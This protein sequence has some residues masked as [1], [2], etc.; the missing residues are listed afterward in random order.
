VGAPSEVFLVDLAVEHLAHAVEAALV[1][2]TVST[3][4]RPARCSSSR[5]VDIAVEHQA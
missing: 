5:R 4:A 2:R 3:W 1:S